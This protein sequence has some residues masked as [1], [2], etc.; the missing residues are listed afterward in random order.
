MF[1]IESGRIPLTL[2]AD[3]GNVLRFPPAATPGV[4]R[5]KIDP[6]TEDGIREQIE[7]TLHILRDTSL[8]GGLAV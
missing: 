1:A 8:V 2:D 6:P 7:K 3:F 5:L 4:L